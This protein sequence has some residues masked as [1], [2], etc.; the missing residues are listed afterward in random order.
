MLN[1]QS[2]EVPNRVCGLLS[3]RSAP[4]LSTPRPF[5][6]FLPWESV[7]EP[8]SHLVSAVRVTS[9]SLR[10]VVHE[11]DLKALESWTNLL[12]A[13]CSGAQE[14]SFP[15]KA[16]SLDFRRDES[17]AA[18]ARSG[19]EQD[20]RRG[21]EG[22]DAAGGGRTAAKGRGEGGGGGGVASTAVDPGP[23]FPFPPVLSP[24]FSFEAAF[25]ALRLE[26]AGDEDGGN[27]VEA[28]GCVAEVG[29]TGGAAGAEQGGR[30]GR[31]EAA[32]DFLRKADGVR[33]AVGC[34]GKNFSLPVESGG[35]SGMLAGAD[36]GA[37]V[38]RPELS[39]AS[40]HRWR[41]RSQARQRSGA[42]SAVVEVK[43]VHAGVKTVASSG[44]AGYSSKVGLLLF[45]GCLFQKE[46]IPQ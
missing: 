36:G 17:G 6:V 35:S 28:G 26:V 19:E 5:L 12:A 30:S 34:G 2:S 46:F 31:P 42:P 27:A 11:G 22:G 21:D 39:G 40:E 9:S 25:E 4:C 1:Y 37:D 45:G 20:S 43:G 3:D 41:R 38:A 10:G 18:H 13:S 23:Y 8:S 16:A 14:R 7:W 33:A 32:E 44:V 24:V 15:G 29:G